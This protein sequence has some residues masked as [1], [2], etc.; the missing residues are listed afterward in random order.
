LGRGGPFSGFCL[1]RSGV[2]K[3]NY[4]FAMAEPHW[5]KLVNEV[6]V[7]VQ[8][9]F[10]VERKWKT[11]LTDKIAFGSQPYHIDPLRMGGLVAGATIHHV[12]ARSWS[13]RRVAT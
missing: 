10:G 13:E 7:G 8:V 6:A 12:Y 1:V 5:S 11:V 3:S 9:R 2:W 4:A